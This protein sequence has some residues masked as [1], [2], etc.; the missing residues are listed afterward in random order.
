M[1]YRLSISEVLN[2]SFENL[3]KYKIGAQKQ[4]T[5]QKEK[6]VNPYTA[7]NQSIQ[8]ANDLKS[9]EKVLLHNSVSDLL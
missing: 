8:Q 6:I 3:E 1:D 2:N 7:L 4:A 9:Q 5:D